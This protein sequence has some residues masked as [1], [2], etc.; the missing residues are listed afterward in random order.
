MS[1]YF[2][3]RLLALIPTLFFSSI[4]VFVSVRLIP[5]DTIDLM[6]AQNDISANQVTREDLIRALG[7]DVPLLEQYGRWVGRILFHFDLGNSLWTQQSVTELISDR[8]PAT[9]QLGIMSLIVSLLISIPIGVISA[10]R[11]DTLADY[12]GR[13]VAILALAVPVF[14]FGTMVIVLPATWWGV[15]PTMSYVDFVSD[16][17]LSVRQMLLPSIVL[18][19]QLAGITMRMTRTMVLETLGQDYVR[20]AWA[21]GLDETTVIVRHVLKNAL[22]PVI[23]IIGLQVP[24]M[25]GG[26]VIVERVFDISGMGQL[27]LESVSQRDYPV[28]TGIFLLTGFGVLMINLFVDLSYAVLDP[29][30]RQG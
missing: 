29:K 12:L 23:T 4:I 10:V 27:L 24:I 14:W 2:V 11:Q 3:H 1:S 26:A 9:L 28:V 6:L 20:T 16:P 5:G 15:P 8:L 25:L 21:K 19:T 7:L 13:S 22:L 17:L 18:G 30:I